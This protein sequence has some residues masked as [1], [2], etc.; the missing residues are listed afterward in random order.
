[1]YILLLFSFLQATNDVIQSYAQSM[2][3]PNTSIQS[4]LVQVGFFDVEKLGH[5]KIN[6]ALVTTL[7]EGRN[8]SHTSFIFQLVNVQ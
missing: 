1:M 5:F 8:L 3:A 6:D 4:L 2:S 7:I